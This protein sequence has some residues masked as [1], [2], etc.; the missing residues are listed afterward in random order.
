[1]RKYY[2]E[3][4]PLEKQLQQQEIKYQ[5][6]QQ[7]KSQEC[8][9]APQ[10]FHLRHNKK[11]CIHMK[12][13]IQQSFEEV[14]PPEKDSPLQTQQEI[15]DDFRSF[16]QNLSRPKPRNISLPKPIPQPLMK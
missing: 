6:V 9:L 14:N 5:M 2:C 13:F 1:M 8:L 16:L 10:N 7:S 15:Q 11:S 4:T 12:D 3:V